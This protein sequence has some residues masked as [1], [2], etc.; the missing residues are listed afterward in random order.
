MSEFSI[1]RAEWDRDRDALRSV[2]TR[3]FVEEQNVPPELEWDGLDSKCL[4]MLAIA[5]HDA[6]GTGRLTPDGHIGRMA[7]VATW[8]GR[9]VGKALLE[10]L[11]VA[12]R[13]RGDTL[14]QLNAQVTAIGFYERFGFKTHGEAFMDAGI[15]H[16]AMSLQ[17]NASPFP[18]PT[19]DGQGKEE[20]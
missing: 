11:M 13:E 10:A 17:L 9:N 15:E 18:L 2:R 8:R 7:V 16:R 19:S 6:I 14:C 5:D 4:H 1:R 20:R 3:V 12:A